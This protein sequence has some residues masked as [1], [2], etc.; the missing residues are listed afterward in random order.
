MLPDLTA[1]VEPYRVIGEECVVDMDESKTSVFL[2]SHS[3]TNGRHAQGWC[4]PWGK[5]K[6][7]VLMPGHS[8]YVFAHPMTARCIDN[9]VTWLEA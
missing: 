1:G 4:H 8:E 7:V 5:G 3:D 6:A 9:A 2:E